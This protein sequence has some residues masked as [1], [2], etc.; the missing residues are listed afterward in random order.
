MPSRNQSWD[1]PLILAI[2]LSE[3]GNEF[4]LF[5][6][7]DDVQDRHCRHT[8]DIHPDVVDHEREGNPANGSSGTQD[9]APVSGELLRESRF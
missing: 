7:G 1:F 8:Q 6:Y 2:F 5:Q 9:D 3:A 4:P